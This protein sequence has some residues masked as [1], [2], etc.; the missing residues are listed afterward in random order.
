M[1]LPLPSFAAAEE[2]GDEKE[3]G[4][5]RSMVGLS[6]AQFIMPGCLSAAIPIDSRESDN[7]LN[8][9]QPQPWWRSQRYRE[10]H[11]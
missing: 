11:T 10:I 5:G 2:E 9:I 1:N 6:I 4:A 7:E 8:Y 3:F